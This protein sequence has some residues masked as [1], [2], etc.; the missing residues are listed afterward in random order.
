M[1]MSDLKKLIS[2][3]VFICFILL[4]IGSIIRDKERNTAKATIAEL[5]EKLIKQ[6]SSSE[7][8]QEEVTT[9]KNQINLQCEAEE[10]HQL[11]QNYYQNIETMLQ[12]AREIE[13]M[14]GLYPLQKMLRD[15][16][17]HNEKLEDR[18]KFIELQIKELD[19]LITQMRSK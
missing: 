2:L 15:M 4:F 5:Q 17:K 3:F 8:L 10:K 9:L 16:N 14:D 7:E 19:R 6:I 13:V 1:I 18:V 12:K 11:K